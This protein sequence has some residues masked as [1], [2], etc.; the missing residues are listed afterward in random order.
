MEYKITGYGHREIKSLDVLDQPRGDAI[1]DSLAD[2]PEAIIHAIL[3]DKCR[4]V[5]VEIAGLN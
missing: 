4:Y 2:V 3:V 1:I 5:T